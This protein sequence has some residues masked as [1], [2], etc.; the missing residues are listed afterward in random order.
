MNGRKLDAAGKL[1]IRYVSRSA[2]CG[3]CSLRANC[4]TEKAKLRT[5]YRWEHE[6]VIERHFGSDA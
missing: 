3:M 6:D 5:V 4:L 1:Q 2:A